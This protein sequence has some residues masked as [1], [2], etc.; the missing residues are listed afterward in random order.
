MIAAFEENG[1]DID[2]QAFIHPQQQFASTLYQDIDK[3]PHLDI[4]TKLGFVQHY[5][6]R[7]RNRATE[8]ETL[9]SGPGIVFTVSNFFTD[10]LADEGLQRVSIVLLQIV[11]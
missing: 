3:Y 7:L 11:T 5:L 9:T 1:T 2:V 6:S 4:V 8:V 10:F